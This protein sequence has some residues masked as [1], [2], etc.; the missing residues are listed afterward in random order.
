MKKLLLLLIIPFLS[1]GQEGCTDEI[2][3]NYDSL[4]NVD[5]GSC[6]FV[7]N[8]S[9]DMTVGSGIWDSYFDHWCT[10]DWTS[11]SIGTKN[12]NSDG[13]VTNANNGASFATWSMCE[14]NLNF[15]YSNGIIRYYNYQPNGLLFR[16]DGFGPDSL[17]GYFIQSTSVSMEELLDKS[18]LSKNLITTVDILGRET[19][20]KVFQLHIYDD[21]SVEKKYLIK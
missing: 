12:F 6:V 17:C 8:P 1:F 2:A 13:T 19:N 16:D 4:A 3:C 20:N 18:L 15:R 14:D 7:S 11:V 10:G 9:V 5:D 21:G